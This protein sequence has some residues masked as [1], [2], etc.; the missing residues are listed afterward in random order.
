[1]RGDC[2]GSTLISPQVDEKDQLIGLFNLLG[3]RNKRV[4]WDLVDL[5]KG[6]HEF[7]STMRNMFSTS[8]PNC[9]TPAATVGAR[10]SL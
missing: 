4:S 8:K 3:V 9:E 7:C 10:F 2:S 5:G 6:W 1:M